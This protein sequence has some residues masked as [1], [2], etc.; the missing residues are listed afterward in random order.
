M[1]DR[2]K[3]L[4]SLLADEGFQAVLQPRGDEHQGEYVAPGSERLKWLTGFSGSAGLVAVTR[5]HAGLF[6]DG[7]YTVQ[8]RAECGGGAFDLPGI[9]HTA[10]VPWLKDKLKSGDVIGFDPWLHTATEIEKLKD[11]LTDTA[12]RK[13]ASAYADTTKADAPTKGRGIIS[14]KAR[15][16]RSA[17]QRNST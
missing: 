14:K 12:K 16:R 10:L 6:V 7:R 3:R 4:R 8:A 13:A 15:R 17:K 5:R 11:K 2:L 9:G 1:P